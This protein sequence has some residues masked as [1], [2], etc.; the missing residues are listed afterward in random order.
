MENLI[1]FTAENFDEQVLASGVPVLVDYW[2]PW[3]GPCRILGP[4]V[5]DIAV[6]LAGSLKVGKINVEEEPEL[7]A[8][9][10]VRGIPTVVL[11]RGGEVAG[12]ALGAQPKGALEAEL[13]LD[14]LPA[15]R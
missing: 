9:A 14:A 4:V 8:R 10:G 5:D 7:A 12:Q 6:E 11:Y 1:I 2:A 15:A 3:W 13:G